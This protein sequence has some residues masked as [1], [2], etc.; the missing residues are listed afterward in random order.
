LTSSPEGRALEGFF[1]LLSGVA[2]EAVQAEPER[3]VVENARGERVRLLE[4]HADEAP[5]GHGIDR[6]AVD[7]AAAVMHMALESK[8]THQV[9]HAIE[10][11][12]HGALPAP[13]LTDEGRD[14][15]LPDWDRRVA[16]RS[17]SAVV[18]I[19]DVAVE[20]DVLGSHHLVLGPSRY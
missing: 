20:D 10:A 5:D 11:A 7:V 14:R 4:H 3:H 13:R 15:V 16:H 17:E 6:R 12:Q 9:V 2:L 1:D 19:P 8:P 18:E